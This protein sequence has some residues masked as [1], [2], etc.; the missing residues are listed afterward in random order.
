M[1]N[2]ILL[3][4]SLSLS[5]SLSLYFAVLTELFLVHVHYNMHR[6]AHLVGARFFLK[7]EAEQIVRCEGCITVRIIR[8]MKERKK[9]KEKSLSF[10]LLLLLLVRSAPYPCAKTQTTTAVS[11]LVCICSQE[12]NT[13]L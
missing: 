2:S 6:M 12:R 10:F 7:R 4:F 3:F 1:N 8:C 9:E 5:L 11:M 13:L